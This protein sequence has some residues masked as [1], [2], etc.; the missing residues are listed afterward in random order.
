MHELAVTQNILKTALEYAESA[1]ARQIT[2]IH[3]VIGE[4][5]SIVDDSVAFYWEIIAADTIAQHAH[6]HFERPA[7]RLQCQDCKH[8]YHPE[9][10][11]NCPICGSARVQF[12]SGE[13]FYLDSIEIS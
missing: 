6:L 9:R 8:I 4:L 1:G 3:L 7:A 2:D 11:F 5:V 13:E 12:I 10:E